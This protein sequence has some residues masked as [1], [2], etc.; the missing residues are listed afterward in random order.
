MLKIP[1][2]YCCTRLTLLCASDYAMFDRILPKSIYSWAWIL[3]ITELN[4]GCLLRLLG[5][6]WR[7]HSSNMG[8]TCSLSFKE[9]TCFSTIYRMTKMC[10]QIP[11][12]CYVTLDKSHKLSIYFSTCPLCIITRASQETECFHYEKFGSS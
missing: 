1:R 10:S 6:L 7:R 4:T 2:F 12:I 9:S 8:E 11:M 3:S 5:R